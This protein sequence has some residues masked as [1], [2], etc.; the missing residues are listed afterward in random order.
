MIKKLSVTFL[1]IALL[2]PS[3]LV[4]QDWS[5]VVAPYGLLPSISGDA[6]VGRIDD[7]EVELDA[8]DVL[9]SLEFGAMLQVEARHK[10]GYGGS[11]NYAFMNLGQN[12]EGPLGFTDFDADIFQGLLEGYGTYRFE[13]EGGTLDA[14]A[15]VRWWDI[16]IDVDGTTPRGSRSLDR[17]EDWVDPVV[18]LR[19]LPRIADKWR[20]FLQGDVG[21]FDIASH[22]TW[23]AQ[24]GA[25]WDCGESW[26]LL[27]LYKIMSVDYETG[28]KN[29]PSYFSYDTITQGPLIGAVFRF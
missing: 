9:E 12:A 21:G 29:T 13:L 23:H 11:L 8:G 15:G 19:W 6:A 5:Y 26:S 17:D 3:G 1:L 27:L 24:A 4:A 20:L 2:A 18:G 16:G 28:T 7:A 22:F 10:S 14:Y 25:M